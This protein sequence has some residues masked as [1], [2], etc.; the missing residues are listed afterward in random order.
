MP[1]RSPGASAA[2]PACAPRNAEEDAGEG[3]GGPGTRSPNGLPWRR[4]AG[5]MLLND[6][7]EAFAGRRKD[8]VAP[9]WQMPQGG[10]GPGEAPRAAALRELAEETGVTQVE[11]LGESARWHRYDLPPD[12]RGRVW[13]GRYRGQEQKWFAMLFLGRDDDID[14]GGPDAEF[15]SWRWV[16]PA[17]LAAEIVPFKRAVYEAVAAEFAPIIEALTRRGRRDGPPANA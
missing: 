6:R 15:S 8:S 5:I 4:G 14:I 3:A 2:L 7:G 13:K 9:A 12:L 16:P 1:P 11:I 10:I 17:V